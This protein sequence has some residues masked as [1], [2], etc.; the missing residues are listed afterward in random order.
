MS[1]QATP[2]E[3]R[4]MHCPLCDASP[5]HPCV[6]IRKTGQSGKHYGYVRGANHVERIEAFKSNQETNHAES[7]I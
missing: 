4:T 5:G 3:V 6:E 2:V 1:R 7:E